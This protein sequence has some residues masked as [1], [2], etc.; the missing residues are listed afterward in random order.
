G[1]RRARGLSAAA[2]ALGHRRPAAGGPCRDA[3]PSLAW[4]P[5]PPGAGGAARPP[6]ALVAAGPHHD[7]LARVAACHRPR[8]LR[9][10]LRALLC[11]RSTLLLAPRLF[12][13][14]IQI[15]GGIA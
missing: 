11:A 13:V 4:G 9:R 7:P 15:E 14:Q 6:D 5:C 2:A 12:R 1:R 10:D 8:A 3:R